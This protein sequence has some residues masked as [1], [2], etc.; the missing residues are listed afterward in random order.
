MKSESGGNYCDLTATVTATATATAATTATAT[1]A[2]TA[3]AASSEPEME[4]QCNP[5]HSP[6]LSFQNMVGLVVNDEGVSA[7]DDT[8]NPMPLPRPTTD[9]GRYSSS[10]TEKRDK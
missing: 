3:T 5:L 7:E 2:T 1:A 9:D 8:D 6:F 4:Y 10:D